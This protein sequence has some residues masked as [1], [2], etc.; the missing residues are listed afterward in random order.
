M[1]DLEDQKRRAAIRAV[2]LVTDGMIVGLGTG[3]T[4]SY[5]VREIG[6]RVAQGL[7]ITATATSRATEDLA[8][9]LGIPLIAFSNLSSVDLAID[10][11]DEIDLTLRAIKG[12]GGA[13]F[14]EKIVAASARRTVI[15]VDST[16]PVAQLGRFKL[17]VEVHAFALKFVERALGDLSLS[18]TLR[19]DKQGKPFLTDQEQY[20]FDLSF[21]SIEDPEALAER[22]DAIP[23][24]IEH[25]LFLTEIDTLIVGEEG[26]VRIVERPTR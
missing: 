5:A 11:A 3:S 1:S 2:E 4:A 26:A 8:R 7:K 22:L 21:G 10:G 14:R 23:G 19:L 15:I 16:K 20:I 17:P 24:L 18:I 13:L 6:L 25:G 9:S 12:G